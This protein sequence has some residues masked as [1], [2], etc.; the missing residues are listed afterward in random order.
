MYSKW[1]KRT[2][3]LKKHVDICATMV[4]ASSRK[5]AEG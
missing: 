2:T 1:G 3:V 4:Y 5:N